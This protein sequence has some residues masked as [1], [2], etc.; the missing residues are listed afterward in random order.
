MVKV[1]EIVHILGGQRDL[2]RGHAALQHLPN[3]RVSKRGERWIVLPVDRMTRRAL[4][5][6]SKRHGDSDEERL[7]IHEE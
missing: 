4:G 1:E 6:R 5:N 2:G 7:S 3:A